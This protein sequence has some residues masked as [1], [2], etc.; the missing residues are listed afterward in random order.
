MTAENGMGCITVHQ[1]AINSLDFIE[2]LQKLRRK[3][4]K[5]SIALFMDN[6]AVHKSRDV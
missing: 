4:V 6:L 5:R 3:H 1:Q 2:F